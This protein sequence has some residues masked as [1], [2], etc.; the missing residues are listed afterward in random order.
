M[1][2][3]AVRLHWLACGRLAGA[4]ATGGGDKTA[5]FILGGKPS[6]SC[7]SA[8]SGGGAGRDGLD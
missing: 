2:R 7:S 3:L 1:D 8:E 6:C 5:R 4:A